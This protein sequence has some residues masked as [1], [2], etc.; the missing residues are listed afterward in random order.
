M[1]TTEI[2]CYI[3]DNHHGLIFNPTDIRRLRQDYRIIGCL[4]G[5]LPEYP[6]QNNELGLPLELSIEECCLLATQKII[7]LYQMILPITDD[8][9]DHVQYLSELDIEFEKQKISNGHE[10]INEIV[11]NRE[12]ILQKT[13]SPS[14]DINIEFDPFITSL[15]ETNN[16]WKNSSRY[17]DDHERSI[18][19]STIQQRLKHF[20]IDYMLLK[21]PLESNRINLQLHSITSSELKEKLQPIEQLRCD[22]FADLYSNPTDKYWISNGQ[23]FGGDF[24]IYLDDPSRCHSSFIITCVLRHEIDSQS[25]IIPLTHLIARCRIAV[26]VNKT[27]ILASRKSLNSSEIDYLTINWNGF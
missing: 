7:S 19:L 15:L 27:F 4:T 2:R 6:R 13:A 1:S 22:V 3:F 9:Q 14:T 11:L 20:T 25:T 18:L 17:F 8:K 26:N 12:S 23:K 21:L 5:S 24:L 10:K 16:A